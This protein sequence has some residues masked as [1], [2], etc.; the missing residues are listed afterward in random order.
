MLHWLLHLLCIINFSWS[1]YWDWYIL[2]FPTKSQDSRK[3]FGGKNIKNLNFWNFSKILFVLMI[4]GQW[5]FL[6]FINLWLQL[7]Y[8]TI[9]FLNNLFGSHSK[10]ITSSSNL[11]KI[12]D[13]LFATLA[14]PI[15]QFVGII[16]WTL[17][18]S[19]LALT[20]G[21]FGLGNLNCRGKSNNTDFYHEI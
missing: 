4:T 15:G 18:V 7:L 20:A 1:I 5:K 11:Q 16:F 8:F 9:S 6:T 2:E 14:F 17:F 10:T 3:S 19:T 13:Y 12:R 21:K